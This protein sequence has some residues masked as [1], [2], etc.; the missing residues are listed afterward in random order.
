[1][2]LPSLLSAGAFAFAAYA[3]VLPEAEDLSVADTPNP[4]TSMNVEPAYQLIKLDCSTCP[5]ALN[6]D[7]SGVHEWTADVA[8][9]LEIKVDG[10]GNRLRFNSIPFYPITTPT[11]PPALYVAQHKK[12]MDF[13]TMEGYHGDLKLSYS[14]EFEEKKLD[15][16]ILVTVLMTVMGLDGQMVNVDDIKITAVKEP[17]GRVGCRHLYKIK[18]TY[19]TNS[20]SPSTPP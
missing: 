18:R 13:S 6:S 12:D 7:R 1:M 4:P 3:L 17:D 15:D 16:N 19:L 8:S 9:D 11:L 2:L 5:Y 20:S 14:L 10:E